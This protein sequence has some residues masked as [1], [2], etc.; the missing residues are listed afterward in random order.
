MFSLLSQRNKETRKFDYERVGTVFASL[1]D[2]QNHKNK[3]VFY[4]NN[5]LMRKLK[6]QLEVEQQHIQDD[7]LRSFH[8]RPEIQI[9][10]V[11]IM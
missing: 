4:R 1:S 7:W 8:V 5:T 2:N 9:F 6:L 3:S 11:R 10:A